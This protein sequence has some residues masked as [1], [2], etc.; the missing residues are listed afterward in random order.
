MRALSAADRR[1]QEF[2]RRLLERESERDT[3]LAKA[4]AL[5]RALDSERTAHAL[6]RQ[7]LADAQKPAADADAAGSGDLESGLRRRGVTVTP[8]K[9]FRAIN[10]DVRVAGCADMVD[11]FFLRSG[12]FLFSNA[13]ARLYFLVYLSLLHIWGFFIV[14]FHTHS[15]AH[16]AHTFR[17][18]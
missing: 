9:R 8:L 13:G 6:T 14:T 4:T 16:D 15:L 2:M 3:A 18:K 7:Q 11:R 17:P 10:S 12:L 1:I 5:A